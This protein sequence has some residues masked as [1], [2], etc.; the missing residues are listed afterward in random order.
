VCNI[1]TMLCNKRILNDLLECSQQKPVSTYSGK[2]RWMF[3]SSRSHTQYTWDRDPSPRYRRGSSA[4]R[5]RIRPRSS[6]RQFC[7]SSKSSRRHRSPC[8]YDSS[9]DTLNATQ[10]NAN[11]VNRLTWNHLCTN[12]YNRYKSTNNSTRFQ[13]QLVHLENQIQLPNAPRIY[14][15]SL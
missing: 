4:G 7:T 13:F 11:N 2:C 8:T 5:R 12:I 6:W 14:S 1:P 15:H 9:M 3:W 10:H